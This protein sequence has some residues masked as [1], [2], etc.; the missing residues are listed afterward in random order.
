MLTVYDEISYKVAYLSI[1]EWIHHPGFALL[2]W[3]KQGN[4][5]Q[6]MNC[7]DVP[8]TNKMDYKFP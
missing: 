1:N 5:F 6:K 8:I 2:F 7:T 4:Y 3:P